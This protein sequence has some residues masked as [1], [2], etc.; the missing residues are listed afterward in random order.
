MGSEWTT[1]GSI[2][3]VF[4][5]PHATPNKTDEGPYFLSIS[6]L[7]NGK[8]DLSKSARLSEEQFSK[9]TRRVTPV[10][11]DVLFSYE[12]RLGE[13]ALMP[14]GIR[15]CLGRRM[16][17][18]RPLVC[19]VLPRYLLFAYLGPDFQ[20]EIRSRTNSGATVD[21]LSLKELADFPIRV[22]PLSEQKAIADILGSLDDKIEL[23]RQINTTLE[24]MAQAL[25]KSWFVDFDPVIDNALAA[26]NPIPDELAD[27]AERRAQAA[28]QP[29]PE[30]PHTL[31]THIRQQFPDRFVFTEEMGWVPE[32]WDA[33]TLNTLTSKIGSGS[34]PRGGSQVYI[35]DGVSLIR[36]Q[37][38]YDS[39]FV[40]EGLARITDEAAAQLKGVTVLEG[41]VLLNITGA[42]ILRTCIAPSEALPARVNQH[43]A[44]IRPRP[45]VPSKYLHLHLLNASTKSYLMG[46]NAGASREA[47]TKT[48][49]ESV[50]TLNPG[51][52]VLAQ[53]AEFVSSFQD[54][55]AN[56]SSAVRTLSSLRDR[57]LPKLLSGQLRIPEAEQLLAEAL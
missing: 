18:L 48:H 47:V 46:Q 50:P 27:R 35:E 24:A 42:S 40:W 29:S 44:I 21:R 55:A 3:T 7:E 54:C 56:C 53:F 57:L 36:S 33:V 31:P 38:V 52:E 22:P 34:T 49:I 30:Q 6:S 2:A 17:L 1:I 20:K 16:G 23:N 9:W 13:A 39:K 10:E 8:L 32:R 26:G 43:V 14:Q 11:G 37:N 19:K 28:Q 12:T 41:D 4:D 5:G 15:A 25:F 51:V 45:G